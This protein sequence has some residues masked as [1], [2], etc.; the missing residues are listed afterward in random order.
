MDKNVLRFPLLKSKREDI[1]KYYLEELIEL[2]RMEFDDEDQ[3][4]FNVIYFHLF[5][6]WL[7]YTFITDEGTQY[8]FSDHKPE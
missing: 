4:Y 3:G 1:F 7:I 5:Q 2:S 8:D 6:S